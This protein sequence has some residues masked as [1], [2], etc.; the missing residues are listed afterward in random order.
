M[1]IDELCQIL[2]ASRDD[3]FNTLRRGFVRQCTDHIVSL[4]V[5]DHQQRPAECAHAGM[6]RFYLRR[7]IVRHRWPVR[8]VLGI[9]V[10]AKSLAFGVEHHGAV[11][12]LVVGFEPT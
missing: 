11:I 5:V 4:D 10:V 2:V 7:Q 3:A 12:R 1:R 8:L 9:P 6:Q